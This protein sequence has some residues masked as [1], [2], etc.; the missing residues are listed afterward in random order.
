MIELYTISVV[1][2]FDFNNLIIKSIMI[3]FNEILNNVIIY[4]SPYVLCVECLFL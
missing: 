2:S 3:F 4:V 1:E